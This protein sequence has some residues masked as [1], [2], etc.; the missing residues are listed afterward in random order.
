MKEG[1]VRVY[2]QK[3]VNNEYVKNPIRKK[4]KKNSSRIIDSTQTIE[5][6]IKHTKYH[7]KLQQND[8]QKQK[9]NNEQLKIEHNNRLLFFVSCQ[10]VLISPSSSKC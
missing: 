5:T 10:S 9:K 8:D 3:N 2:G 7:S 1:R 4:Q 6:N